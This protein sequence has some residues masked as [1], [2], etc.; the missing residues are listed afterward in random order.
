MQG[1]LPKWRT[2]NPRKRC[3]AIPHPT[4]KQGSGSPP[5]TRDT[6]PQKKFQNK[7]SA[8]IEKKF[9]KT[10]EK[11]YQNYYLCSWIHAFKLGIKKFTPTADKNMQVHAQVKIS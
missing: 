2:Q 4:A 6:E 1:K 5:T 3:S 10:A 9:H 7:F 8:N 11:K